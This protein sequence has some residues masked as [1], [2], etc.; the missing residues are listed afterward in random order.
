M[1]TVKITNCT[2][3][4]EYLLALKENPD[5][6]LFFQHFRF[7]TGKNI[8]MLPKCQSEHDKDFAKYDSLYGNKFNNLKYFRRK[9]IVL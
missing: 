5:L 7:K 3:Y 1:G 2:E 4:K 9:L 8:M 6:D